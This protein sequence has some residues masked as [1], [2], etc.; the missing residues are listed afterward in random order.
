MADILFMD[1]CQS[2]PF[3]AISGEA[4]LYLY[5]PVCGRTSKHFSFY[6]E[7]GDRICDRVDVEEASASWNSI[8]KGGNSQE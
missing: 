2:H 7:G 6:R 4:D 1:C 8:V 3:A 5:C